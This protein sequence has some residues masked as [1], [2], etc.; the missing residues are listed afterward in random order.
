MA[1]RGGPMVIGTDGADFEHRQ[2]VA[3]HYQISA[4]NK[5]RLKYCIFFHYLLF[6]VMLV[7]LSADILDRLD[8][9]ILEIEELQIPQPLWWEY[10][11]CLSVFLSYFGLTAARRNRIND[12]KKYMVGISTVAFVPLLYCLIY[13]LNDVSE[14]ISLE[15]GTELEDTDIFVWQ[16]IGY[17]YGLLWYGFVL[18]A[19][20]VHFFS[21][22]FAWNLIKAWR[23]RGTLR[24]EQ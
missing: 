2:R 17:P 23:A 8:I 3:A 22:Y 7:K 13:Y 15:K 24:K 18:L 5:A 12:M 19:L 21:L 4:L 10:F 9:F 6:F 16:V 11:W 14:Y 20:Q 1:S